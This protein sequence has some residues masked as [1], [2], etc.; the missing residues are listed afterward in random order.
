MTQATT[1]PEF[2]TVETFYSRTSRGER[3]DAV[4]IYDRSTLSPI[5]EVILPGNKRFQG[6]PARHALTLI[7]DEKLLVVFNF[8]P[9]ASVS[10]IDIEAREV[11]SEIQT[12]GCVLMYPTGTHG[13]TG[14]CSNGGLLTTVVDDD[15]QLVSQTRHDPFFDT[16]T[17]PI[18]DRAAIV[19]GTAYF[20]GFNGEVWP[21][22]LSGETAVVG[23]MW[24]LVTEEEAAANWRPGGTAVID[25]DDLGRIYVIMHPDGAEGTHDGGGP[26]VWIFDVATQQRVQ[27]VELAMWGISVAV[28]RG[29][30]PLMVVTNGDFDLDVYDAQTGEYVRTITGF[31]QE[32]PFLVTGAR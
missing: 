17:S 21:V 14:V 20:P 25:K 6:M 10:I 9:A 3:T 18:S 29:D 4:T 26:E 2:Y 23:D 19:D 15:G 27:R 7:A 22:D 24:S 5:D 30:N 8:N 31:G 32:T 1:R 13:F 28:T 16:D 11:V 12:P